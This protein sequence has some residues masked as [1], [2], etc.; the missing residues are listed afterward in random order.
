MPTIVFEPSEVAKQV[1][2][3]E[4]VLVC[5][6]SFGVEYFHFESVGALGVMAKFASGAGMCFLERCGKYD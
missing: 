6:L 2:P 4:L 1:P 5:L 3:S